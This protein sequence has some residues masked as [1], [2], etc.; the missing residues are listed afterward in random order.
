MGLTDSCSFVGLIAS[1]V[2]ICKSLWIKA[3]TKFKKNV[4]II[5]D[6]YDNDK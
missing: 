1:L 4:K 5:N 2:L 3:S 6:K